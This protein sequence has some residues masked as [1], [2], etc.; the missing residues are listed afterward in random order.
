MNM[1][2]PKHEVN[3]G[4]DLSK[5]TLSFFAAEPG[6]YVKKHQTIQ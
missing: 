5:I 6:R 3:S 4:S 1:V 2:L